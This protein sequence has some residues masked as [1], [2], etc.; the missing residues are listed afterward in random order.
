MQRVITGAWFQSCAFLYANLQWLK[1]YGRNFLTHAAIF[2]EFPSACSVSPGAGPFRSAN[3]SQ[4][5]QKCEFLPRLTGAQLA[6]PL[7]P[8]LR[9]VSIAKIPNYAKPSLAVGDLPR[10]RHWNAM[11]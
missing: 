8:C 1:F 11:G 7:L 3:H 4:N 5:F 9:E 2:L 6:S 10:T